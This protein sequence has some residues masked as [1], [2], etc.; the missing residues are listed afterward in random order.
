M[1]GNPLADQVTR[2]VLSYFLRNPQAAD[3]VEGVARWRLLNEIVHRRVDETQ[4]ALAWLVEAGFLTESAL[5]GVEPVYRLRPGMAKA[6]ERLL[7]GADG[8]NN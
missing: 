3:S 1:H 5:T 4:Q 2:D 8:T 7:G 6:A